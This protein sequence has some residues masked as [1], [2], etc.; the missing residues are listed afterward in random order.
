MLL[1]ISEL[2]DFERILHPQAAILDRAC[3]EYCEYGMRGKTPE[4][5]RVPEI[6]EMAESLRRGL[7]RRLN[8]EEL[9][10]FSLAEQAI[11][12]EDDRKSTA[13]AA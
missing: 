8:D 5:F 2:P 11:Q 4:R 12:Q 9:E 1:K 7:G 6:A 3:I 10:F 13:T